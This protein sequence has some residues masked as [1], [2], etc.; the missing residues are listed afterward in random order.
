[1]A[2]SKGPQSQFRYCWWYRR[3]HGTDFEISGIAGL[4]LGI[5]ISKSWVDTFY[6][7]TWTLRERSVLEARPKKPADCDNCPDFLVDL[8]LL[9]VLRS[10]KQHSGRGLG[11]CGASTNKKPLLAR[12]PY[13]RWAFEEPTQDDLLDL[14]CWIWK[15]RRPL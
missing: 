9:N 11:S 12:A 4:V 15:S 2:V 6:L 3:F 14:S 13:I 7:G 10:Q 1:M 5:V 8:L